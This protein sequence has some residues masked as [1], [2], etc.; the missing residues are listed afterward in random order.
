MNNSNP[1]SGKCAEEM[2]ARNILHQPA[3]EELLKLLGYTRAT[4]KTP[5]VVGS[6]HMKVD[7]VVEFTT[8]D[9]PLRFNIKSFKEPSPGNHLE[10]RQLPQYC[11]RN[12]ISSED[13][14]FLEFLWKRKEKKPRCR[15]VQTDKEQLRVTE[16][17]TA[18]EPGLSALCGQDHP[19]VLALYHRQR[20]RWHLYDMNTKV[21]PRVRGSQITLTPR[22]GNIC[23]GDYIIIQRHGSDGPGR[24]NRANDVQVKMRA[25]QFYHDVEPCVAFTCRTADCSCNQKI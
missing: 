1:Q 11:K 16:I 7:V 8:Q 23:I 13:Q 21:E 18:F 4:A 20:Q 3:W 12:Q 9:P 24:P 22:G 15:L 2:L 25:S 6:R 17:F 10:R 19:Q 5:Q 14:R